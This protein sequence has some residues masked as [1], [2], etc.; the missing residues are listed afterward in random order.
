[1]EDELASLAAD[2][3][4][5]DAASSGEQRPSP[6][7]ALPAVGELGPLPEA[8][9]ERAQLLLKAQRGAIAGLTHRRAQVREHLDAV[10]AVPGL[11]QSSEAAYLDVSG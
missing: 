4:P 7:V 10:R 3:E 2:L 1:M 6:A 5:S 8:L 9:R 11:R